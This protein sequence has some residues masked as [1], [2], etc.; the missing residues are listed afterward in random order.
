MLFHCA[1]FKLW[2]HAFVLSLKPHMLIQ[3]KKQ[4]VTLIPGNYCSIACIADCTSKKGLLTGRLAAKNHS[5]IAQGS[6]FRSALWEKMK[7]SYL[8]LK[9]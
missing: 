8:F 1:P 7:P 4:P 2:S 9:V 5:P 3:L 6:L